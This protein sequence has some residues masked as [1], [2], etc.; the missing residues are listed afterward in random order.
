M[1]MDSDRRWM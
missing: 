1:R